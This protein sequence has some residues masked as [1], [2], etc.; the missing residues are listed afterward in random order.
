MVH[1]TYIIPGLSE[2]ID[3][4]VLSHYPPT[5]IKR[6]IAAGAISLYLNQNQ[7]IV[8]TIVNNP[9]FNG[10]KVSTAEGMIDI[11]TLRDIYKKEINKAGYLRI[12]FPLLGDVD[13]TSDDVDT[14]YRC[15]M[16]KSPQN[17]PTTNNG[18][19]IV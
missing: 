19:M 15:I 11:E 6:I 7:T 4:T 12:H 3:T 16:S 10:L 9:M 2:F 8:D 13:F 14:L 18:G 5:S 1:K 17:S